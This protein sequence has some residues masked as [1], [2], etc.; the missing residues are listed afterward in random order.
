MS[1]VKTQLNNQISP[2]KTQLRNKMSPVKYLCVYLFC[3]KYESLTTNFYLF[4]AQLPRNTTNQIHTGIL[5]K[6]TISPLGV[7]LKGQGQ[8]FVNLAV[9][10]AIV[11]YT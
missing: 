10:I 4:Y 5:I 11:S 2:V 9:V 3:K 6:W 7:F 1:P 8:V